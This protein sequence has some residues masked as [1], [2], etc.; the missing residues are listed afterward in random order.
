MRHD[1]LG[2]WQ[3]KLVRLRGTKKVFGVIEI[4]ETSPDVYE[5]NGDLKPQYWAINPFMR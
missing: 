2:I 3:G 5:K 1:R 4:K